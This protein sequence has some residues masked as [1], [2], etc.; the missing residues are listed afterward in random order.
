MSLYAQYIKEREG[1]EIVEDNQG[2][3]TYTFV[4]DGVYI[5]DL[6][7]HP[8]FRQKGAASRYAD[9]IAEIAK[10]KGYS[11]MYGSVCLSAKSCDDSLKVLQAYGFKLAHY[12]GGLLFMVKELS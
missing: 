11:K 9:Q 12:D 3:A 1:K 7:V 5:Q 2:F 8:D 4:H 10:S 6:F